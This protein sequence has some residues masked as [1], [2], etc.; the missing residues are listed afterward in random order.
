MK[1]DGNANN[2]NQ[3]RNFAIIVIR[4]FLIEFQLYSLGNFYL[5]H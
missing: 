2:E 1:C 3:E 5:V 4:L